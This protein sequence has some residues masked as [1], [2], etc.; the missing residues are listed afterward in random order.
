MNNTLDREKA[1]LELL[2]E[3]SGLTSAKICENLGVSIVTIR[4]DLKSLE[5]K[6]LLV[7][8]HGGA[9]PAFHQ[10]IL[11]RQKLEI[12]NKR[13][14]ARIAAELVNDGDTIMIEAGTTTALIARYLLGKRNIRIVTNNLLILPYIRVNPSINVTFIGGEFRP[15]TESMV[16]AIALREL[17]QFH[18]SI[19]FV[20]ADGWSLDKGITAHHVEAGE[21]IKRTAEQAD[22]IVLVADSTKYIQTGYVHV[23]PLEKLDVIITNKGLEK[24]IIDDLKESGIKLELI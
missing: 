8:M 15:E 6:G 18:V 5:E 1:I 21:V 7:R 12:E 14:I 17:E 24:S 4:H 9:L 13:K 3:D 19:A 10:G 23:L 16:G 11:N 20:G 22:K 2:S